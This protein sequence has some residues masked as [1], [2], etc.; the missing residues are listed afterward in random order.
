MEPARWQNNQSPGFRENAGPHAVYVSAAR[1]GW[2]DCPT[3][4]VATTN[5]FKDWNPYEQSG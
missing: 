1:S 3:C 2:S 5:V 4:C